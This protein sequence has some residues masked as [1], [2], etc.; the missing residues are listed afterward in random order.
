MLGHY[1]LISLFCL[2]LS[3]QKSYTVIHFTGYLKSWPTSKIN[4]SDSDDI[5]DNCNLSCLV[6]IGQLR[7]KSNQIATSSA[8]ISGLDVRPLEYML[9]V[10][11]DGKLS[12]IDQA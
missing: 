4:I 8:S 12:F 7:T 6:A 1:I 11:V 3:D 9:R 10:T 2:S 5:E